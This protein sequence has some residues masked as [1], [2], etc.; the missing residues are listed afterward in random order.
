MSKKDPVPLPSKKAG[1]YTVYGEDYCRFTR[2]ARQLLL[3][4]RITPIYCPFS[5]YD[6][7]ARITIRKLTRVNH[8]TMPVV[9]LGN[10]HGYEFIGG[11]DKLKEKLDPNTK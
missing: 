5:E 9:F 3:D 1:E 8:S 10:G 6:D 7:E 4:K 11:F 2:D